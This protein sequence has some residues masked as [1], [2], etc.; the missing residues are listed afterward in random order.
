MRNMHFLVFILALFFIVNYSFSISVT[1]CMNITQPGYYQVVN[2]IVYNSQNDKCFYINSSNVTLDFMGHSISSDNLLIGTHAIYIDHANN[3]SV[4]NINSV[5]RLH[6]LVYARDSNNLKFE[7]ISLTNP[8]LDTIGELVEV[9]N[10][11][12]V[13]INNISFNQT[14]VTSHTPPKYYAGGVLSVYDSNNVN[15]SNVYIRPYSEYVECGTIRMRNDNNLHMYNVTLISSGFDS[16]FCNPINGDD[17]KNGYVTPFMLY[18]TNSTI[19]NLHVITLSRYQMSIAGIN[20]NVV[21]NN[22]NIDYLKVIEGNSTI[23]SSPYPNLRESSIVNTGLNLTFYNSNIGVFTL[24]Q[25]YSDGVLPGNFNIHI[26]NST[27]N[28]ILNLPYIFNTTLEINNTVMKDFS[29]DTSKYGKYIFDKSNRVF[30]DNVTDGMGYWYVYSHVGNGVFDNF[31]TD[32]EPYIHLIGSAILYG[33]DIEGKF[34]VTGNVVGYNVTDSETPPSILP[35][36]NSQIFA[37]KIQLVNSDKLLL[38]PNNDT[39]VIYSSNIL[40][41]GNNNKLN[42]LN[43]VNVTAVNLSSS[44]IKNCIYTNITNSHNV[45]LYNSNYTL[46]DNTSYLSLNGYVKYMLIKN[47]DLS[48]NQNKLNKAYYFDIC[49]SHLHNSLYESRFIDSP[50]INYPYKCCKYGSFFDTDNSIDYIDTIHDAK[51]DNLY[52]NNTIN[53]KL[54]INGKY[55]EDISTNESVKLSDIFN[56]VKQYGLGGKYDNVTLS[57]DDGKCNATTSMFIPNNINE[58]VINKETFDKFSKDS[59]GLRYL[60]F[61]SSNVYYKFIS[62]IGEPISKTI[63]F[64]DIKGSVIDMSNL[65]NQ[66]VRPCFAIQDNMIIN[67]LFGVNFRTNNYVCSFMYIINSSVNI[68]PTNFINNNPP[69]PNSVSL[70]MYIVG[71]KNNTINIYN[72]KLGSIYI[73][74]YGNS[75]PNVIFKNINF[76]NKKG[77]QYGNV[78]VSSCGTITINNSYGKLRIENGWSGLDCTGSYKIY[79]TKYA[80]LTS[81]TRIIEADNVSELHIY[82]NWGTFSNL[83][84]IG[85]LYFD[86]NYI[87]NTNLFIKL[88]NSEIKQLYINA[89]NLNNPFIY[90]FTV[91]LHNVKLGNAKL[92]GDLVNINSIDKGLPHYDTS[93]LGYVQQYV[94]FENLTSNKVSGHNANV[95]FNYNVTNTTKVAEYNEETKEW[96]ELNYTVKNNEPCINVVPHSL[97]AVFDQAKKPISHPVQQQPVVKKQI[98]KQGNDNWWILIGVL[99]LIWVVHKYRKS[100][101]YKY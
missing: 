97:Y 73:D 2:D 98:K 34:N 96:K 45:Y 65:S 59:S 38:V 54:F 11:N 56:K 4:Y 3:V 14:N 82:N 91:E 68:I 89:K 70:Q 57:S 85:T 66:Y 17:S 12:N 36:Y 93:K 33:Y 24:G 64:K 60:I 99:I 8:S 69:Q 87:F 20:S 28:D 21:I 77:N 23:Y 72:G 18:N 67:N 43:D 44:N 16:T 47:S 50:Y 7:N 37:N 100:R 79:N 55:I 1:G 32:R 13:T 25:Y 74:K 42:A 26:Y 52:T 15:I 63:I 10:A 78:L 51:V 86:Y 83:H 31:T 58:V 9:Q 71:D 95:C 53:Y 88:Y 29:L 22:S 41:K 39:S 5:G 48:I 35:V 81:M 75:Y 40:V 80:M 49:G 19:N 94:W 101:K 90:K 62:G 27:V 84:N 46:I 92:N 76:T 30:G 61:N 6:F